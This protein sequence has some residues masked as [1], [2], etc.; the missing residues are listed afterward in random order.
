MAMTASRAAAQGPSGFSLASI[1][2]PSWIKWRAAR[3][4]MGSVTMRKA[5]AADAAADTP[6]KERR[7]VERIGPS[8]MSHPLPGILPH[9]ARAGTTF[10]GGR[11]KTA[12]RRAANPR[13]VNRLL[14]VRFTPRLSAM[15]AEF[16]CLPGGPMKRP[17]V[18]ITI[19]LAFALIAFVPGLLPVE[20]GSGPQTAAQ[21]SAEPDNTAAAS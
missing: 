18:A 11:C 5:S 4:S 2:T 13:S 21:Q 12:A 17:F 19:A 3:A 6:R 16:R 14:V 9:N 1:I 10:G 20:A 7:D 15:V 8:D